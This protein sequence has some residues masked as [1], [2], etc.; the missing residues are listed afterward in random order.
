M[1]DILQE[2]DWTAILGLVGTFG[3]LWYGRRSE[4]M[5]AEKRRADERAADQMR[6]DREQSVRW[7]GRRLD[8][9]AAVV[10]SY[11]TFNRAVVAQDRLQAGNALASLELALTSAQ[12]LGGREVFAASAT[13]GTV[14]EAAFA[15]FKADALDSEPRRLETAMAFLATARRELGLDATGWPWPDAESVARIVGAE[16][17]RRG[18]DFDLNNPDPILNKQ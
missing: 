1:A 13:L 18:V 10:T 8:A 6:W 15:N 5:A 4:R 17:A 3:G 12:L 7:H 9:F 2:L 16:A 14:C 11:D